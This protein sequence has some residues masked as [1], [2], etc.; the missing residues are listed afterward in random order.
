MNIVHVLAAVSPDGGYGGPTTVA[1][2]QCA[3]LREAGH[4]VTLVTGVLGYHQPPAEACGQLIRPFPATLLSR[5]VGY[6]T[7]Y[8]RGMRAWLRRHANQFDV[9]HIHIS[10]D[11]VTMPAA[12]AIA[13]SGVP[14]VVQPHGMIIPSENPA[15]PLIDA[16][17][18]RRLLGRA[19][20]VL[21]LNDRERDDIGMVMGRALPTETVSNG[22]P[23]HMSP[24]SELSASAMPE[25]LFMARLHP[26]KRPEVFVR[27]AIELLSVGTKARFTVIGPDGGMQSEVDDLIAASGFGPDRLRREPALAPDHTMER[28]SAASVYVLPAHREPFG[29]T[30]VESLSVQTPVVI[31]RDGGLAD[32]VAVNDC[33]RVVDGTVRGLTSAITGMLADP[34]ELSAMGRRGADAVRAEF[35]MRRVA[36][37]LAD[38]YT[39]SMAVSGDTT[40]VVR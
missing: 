39:A 12:G 27:A 10:R 34:V 40:G 17:A 16:V 9:A 30:V 22:V 35:G 3:A 33:G 23:E 14:Y 32:F 26:R 25:V 21:V 31:C 38:I 13:A 24:P 8:A 28:L 19:Q 5:R 15:A 6:A 20:R 37:Q 18:T 36:D 4:E 1:M 2:N 11:L 7:V 29:M